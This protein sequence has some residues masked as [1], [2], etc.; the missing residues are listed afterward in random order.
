MKNFD[1]DGVVAASLARL[2]P[3]ADRFDCIEYGHAVD[4]TGTIGAFDEPV[5][6]AEPIAIGDPVAVVLTRVKGCTERV[7]FSV[8]C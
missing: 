4:K 8:R 2:V 1:N 7:W 3:D 6:P 5:I